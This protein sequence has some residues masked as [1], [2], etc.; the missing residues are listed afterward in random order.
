LED[1]RA[2]DLG[3]P[4]CDLQRDLA[5]VAVAEEVG[6]RDVQVAEQRDGVLGRLV[7]GEGAVQVPRVAV[8][9]LLERDSPVAPSRRGAMSLPNE[10]SRVEPPPWSSTSG[11][12]SFAGLPW[13]S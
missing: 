2:N 9:L 8:S 5:A 3:M 4:E 7:E 13:I 11:T 6:L 1:E 10:V 12:P